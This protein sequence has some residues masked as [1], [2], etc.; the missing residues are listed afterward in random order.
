MKIQDVLEILEENGISGN[1]FCLITYDNY[2]SEDTFRHAA[3]MVGAVNPTANCT[4]EASPKF[5]KIICGEVSF[6]IT[7][8]KDPR[9]L[10]SELRA[11]S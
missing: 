3:F 10:Y 9:K 5:I 1:D 8:C 4:I 6:K 7:R 11:A 2:E